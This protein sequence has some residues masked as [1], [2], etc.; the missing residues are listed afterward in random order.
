MAKVHFAHCKN[1]CHGQQKPFP[2]ERKKEIINFMTKILG[3]N[4]ITIL[5][6]NK[7]KAEK[8]YIDTLGFEKVSK[9]NHLWI[10]VGNQYIH[11]TDNSGKPNKD[12]FYHFAIEIENLKEYLEE[13]VKKGVS[14][15][16]LDERQNKILVNSDFNKDRRN[17]FINDLDGNL[18]EFIDS[19]NGFFK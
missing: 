19:K 9:G 14:V 4:H 12:T 10:K 8:F 13:I 2:W 11:I 6:S 7:E 15:F 17:Y 5:T 16:D 1:Y 18:I 3:V